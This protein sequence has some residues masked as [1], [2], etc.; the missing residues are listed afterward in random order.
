M[1]CHMTF[2]LVNKL[3][4]LKSSGFSGAYP[5]NTSFSKK[6]CF[7]GSGQE[8]ETKGIRQC[9]QRIR[10]RKNIFVPAAS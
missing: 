10:K 6:D 1:T 8:T 2:F 5:L 7:F 3:F 4:A 9:Q